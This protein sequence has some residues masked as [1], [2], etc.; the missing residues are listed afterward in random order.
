[1]ILQAWQIIRSILYKYIVCIREKALVLFELIGNLPAMRV[2]ASP[3]TFVH[4]VLDN[5]GPIDI[6][7]NGQGHKSHK[8]YIALFIRISTR[9]IHVDLVSIIYP[10]NF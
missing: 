8:G 7:T 3:R 9:A 5:A 6:R 1:M 10:K 4:C 2:N